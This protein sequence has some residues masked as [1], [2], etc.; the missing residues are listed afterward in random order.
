MGEGLCSPTRRTRG[1]RTSWGRSTSRRRSRCAVAEPEA[2]DAEGNGHANGN[3]NGNGHEQG[4]LVSTSVG[5][6]HL[7][8]G[9][10]HRRCKSG[11]GGDAVP[12]RDMD[13][14][15]L[16]RLSRALDPAYGNRVT[17]NV[18]DAIK[19]LGFEYATRSGITIAIGDIK[20][21]ARKAE[22]LADA[23]HGSGPH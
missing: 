23:G 10:R 22:M 8:R 4:V 2:L 7:Q 20:V 11:R 15:S 13:K 14:G 3:G 6:H 1:W 12:Q 18:L 5:R 9:D 16:K 19:R 21:P 17:A